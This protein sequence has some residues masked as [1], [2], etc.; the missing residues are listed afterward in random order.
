MISSI[1]HVQFVIRSGS[2]YELHEK[3]KPSESFENFRGRPW[4]VDAA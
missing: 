2:S 1:G 4:E 3:L